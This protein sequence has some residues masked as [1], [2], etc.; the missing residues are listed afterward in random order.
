MAAPASSAAITAAP[1]PGAVPNAISDVGAESLPILTPEEMGGK[2]LAYTVEL[3]LQTQ[4]FN[5]GMRSL[6]TTV[7]DMGGYV[8]SA[9]VTG[10]DLHTP[11][12]EFERYA[13]YTF[14]LPSARLSEFLAFTEDNY[15]LWH[16]TQSTREATAQYQE[17]E[18]NLP[19]LREQERRLRA[20]IAAGGDEELRARL[21]KQ[22]AETQASIARMAASQAQIEDS[23]IYSMVNVIL[24]EVILPEDGEPLPPLTFSQQL[25]H[26]ARGSVGGLLAFGRGLLIVLVAAGP[27]LLLIAFVFIIVWKLYRMLKKNHALRLSQDFPVSHGQEQE[28]EPEQ[29]KED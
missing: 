16:L 24:Y 26:T 19:D 25:L 4:S 18:L 28:Q 21:E 23:V 10:R 2:K 17:A 6:L 8:V 1:Q 22:L 13:S 15:N 12:H 27:A 7:G 29:E 3:L 20:D 5:A 11:E 14:R 9:E